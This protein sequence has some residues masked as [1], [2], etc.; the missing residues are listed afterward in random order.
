L[1]LIALTVGRRETL[2]LK[3]RL[4]RAERWFVY[5]HTTFANPSQRAQALSH[6]LLALVS[7]RRSHDPALGIPDTLVALELA[8]A[9]LLTEGTGA[10]QHLALGAVVLAVVIAGF[11]VFFVGQ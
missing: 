10:G 3:R 6:E 4:L 7:Q 5:P 8:K 11:A 1:Q 2:R 9:S